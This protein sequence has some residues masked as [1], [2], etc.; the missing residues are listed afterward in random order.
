MLSGALPAVHAAD[1]QAI[2]L[3]LI[4]CGHRGSGRRASCAAD[5]Q[6][7]RQSQRM[8]HIVNELLD[9]ARNLEGARDLTEL[10]R[11]AAR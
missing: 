4:G 5:D 2:R 6:Q 7:H 1:D 9:L 3:A 11:L 10:M 8:I